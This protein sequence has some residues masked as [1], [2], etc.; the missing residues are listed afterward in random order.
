MTIDTLQ[1]AGRAL[2][3]SEDDTLFIIFYEPWVHDIALSKYNEGDLSDPDRPCS[4]LRSR[5]QWRERASL[6]SL[7]LVKGPK[8]LRSEFASYLG[9][10]SV[11]GIVS[12]AF[13]LVCVPLLIK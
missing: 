9:D 1:H 6:S 4:K 3:N 13:D 8:C 5:S 7:R 2:R 11:E 12:L 10:T